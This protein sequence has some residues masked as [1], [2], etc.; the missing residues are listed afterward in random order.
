MKN[1]TG[2]TRPAPAAGCE[3]IAKKAKVTTAKWTATLQTELLGY[4]PEA[5]K[6]QGPLKDLAKS[7]TIR[8]KKNPSTIQI[9][10]AIKR[11]YITKVDKDLCAICDYKIDEKGGITLPWPESYDDEE[12]MEA[13]FQLA[14]KLA[15]FE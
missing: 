10:L 1:T 13:S 4:L 14:C 3:T 11:W 2:V 12:I 15:R 5:A 8:N 9:L 7:Y 6:P